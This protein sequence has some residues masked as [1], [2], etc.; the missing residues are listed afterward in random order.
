MSL[1]Y[2]SHIAFKREAGPEHMAFQRI[3]KLFYDGE[4]HECK[5]LL[6]GFH[7][8]LCIA[9]PDQE[10]EHPFLQGE[11]IHPAETFKALPV[12]MFVGFIT[13]SETAA[14]H[15]V[16]SIIL[17]ACPLTPY[18]KPAGLWLDV[19]LEDSHCPF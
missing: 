19:K 14:H 10:S 15:N 13:T 9:K 18:Q 8:G 4:K 12:Y 17:D 3:G 16:Y 6:F 2:I 7:Q 5:I 11:I 1:S